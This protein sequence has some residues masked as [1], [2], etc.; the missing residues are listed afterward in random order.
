MRGYQA[1]QAQRCIVPPAPVDECV[2]PVPLD[3]SGPCR[4]GPNQSDHRESVRLA[5][6]QDL[7][8][9]PAD[10][11]DRRRIRLIRHIIDHRR[12]RHLPHFAVEE[13]QPQALPLPFLGSDDLV[14]PGENLVVGAQWSGE[15][16]TAWGL[17]LRVS[18]HDRSVTPA[19]DILS[20]VDYPM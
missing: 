11:G 5:V 12:D 7:R 18:S 3:G 16:L 4:S 2:V 17:G 1:Q 10:V 14:D 19:T 9:D 20:T 13:E 8:H 6:R 15:Y